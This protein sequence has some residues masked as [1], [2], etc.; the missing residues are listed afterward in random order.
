[1]LSV[2]DRS[3]RLGPGDFGAF[4]VGTLHAWRNAGE[5]PVRWLQVAAPQPKP[6]GA[7]RDT[8]F[9]KQKQMEFPAKPLDENDLNG[10]LLGHFDAGQIPAPGPARDALPGAKGVFL[11]WLID[12]KFGAR[13]HRLLFIEYLPGSNIPLHDHTFEESLLHS[14]WRDRSGSRREALFGP[15]RR[16]ALDRRGLCAHVCQREQR[17]GALAGNLRAAA[18]GGECVPLHGGVGAA[19]QRTGRVIYCAFAPYRKRRITPIDGRGMMSYFMKTGILLPISALLCLRWFHRSNAGPEPG[20]SGSFSNG[21]LQLPQRGQHHA[22][23][24]A[25]RASKACRSR[26]FSRL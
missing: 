6:H 17:T 2:A 21:L 26:R 23:A 10:A 9:A 15:A 8:F 19:S 11:K 24:P 12:E 25:G 4:K 16:R 22:G 3:W 14:E 13:H 1:M 20:R 7:E 18:S 5:R